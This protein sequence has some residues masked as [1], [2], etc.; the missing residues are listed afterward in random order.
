MADDLARA[1]ERRSLRATQVAT[2]TAAAVALLAARHASPDAEVVA[3][4]GGAAVVTFAVAL[5]RSCHQVRRSAVDAHAIASPRRVRSA[6]RTLERIARLAERGAVEVRAARPPQS[7]LELAP[8][9]SA[10]RALAAA[11][12][13]HPHPTMG[14]VAAC[15]CFAD[16]CWNGALRGHDHET[17]RRELGRIRFVVGVDQPRTRLS[18]G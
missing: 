7:V 9:A 4:A 6:A 3:V 5:A 14:A 12:R 13:S 11:L 17:L 2:A 8:E 1:L 18:A 16:S 10:I 15:E